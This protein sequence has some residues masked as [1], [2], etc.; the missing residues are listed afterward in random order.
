MLLDFLVAMLIAAALALM[1]APFALAHYQPD[2]STTPSDLPEKFTAT[3]T[4]FA[5][6]VERHGQRC[7]L[8][9]G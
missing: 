9:K 2:Q 6:D 7:P 1:A 5:L 3:L 4:S 8:P